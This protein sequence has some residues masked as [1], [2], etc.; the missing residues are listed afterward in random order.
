MKKLSIC[1]INTAIVVLLGL[2]VVL[3]VVIRIMFPVFSYYINKTDRFKV[4]ILRQQIE[5]K[6]YL[7]ITPLYDYPYNKI[8]MEVY[9]KFETDSRGIDVYKDYLAQLYPIGDAI[10]SEA[11]LREYLFFE[12]DTEFSNGTLVS[13]NDAVF[14]VSRGQRRP[15]LGPEA[16]L[17]LGFDWENV[18]TENGQG[19]VAMDEG[20]KINFISAHPDGTIF[21]TKEGELFLIW[22]KERLPIKNRQLLESVWSNNHIVHVASKKANLVGS[23]SGIKNSSRKVSCFMEGVEMTGAGIGSTYVF[24]L[25][26]NVVESSSDARIKFDLLGRTDVWVAKESLKRVKDSLHLKY[27]GFVF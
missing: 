12:N 19:L 25:P 1:K 10:E 17:R 26:R 24:D 3:Y 13:F 27:G 16:F 8:K 22:N 11:K 2:G 15:F 6:N 9:G 7:T 23:C 18:E 14:F 5:S 21:E 20:E 4:Q